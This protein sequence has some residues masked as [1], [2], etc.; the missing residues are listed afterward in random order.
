MTEYITKLNQLDLEIDNDIVHNQVNEIKQIDNYIKSKKPLPEAPARLGLLPDQF[1]D[2]LMEI[3]ENKRRSLTTINNLFN[4][5][6]QYLSLEY[7]IWSVAN[8]KTARLIKEKLAI[9][10]A[11]EI[12][13]G[14]AYWSKALE[15]A[16]IITISTDSLE[17]AKT[18]KTGS[19]P[20]Y[21]VLDMPAAQAIEKYRDVD[22]ILCSWSPN[23]GQGD[24]ETVNAW[25]KYNKSSHLLF[26]GE[27]NGATNSQEFW[28]HSWLKK[29][30]ELAEINHSFKSFDFINEQIF[31]ID[32]EF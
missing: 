17:W 16:G 8:L 27:Q 6:R 10:K 3:G 12:M 18:S 4:N 29:T 1:E 7:G 19:E 26:I 9:N 23:F 22:L 24:I 2:V 25:Q 30:P 20:F 14:N 5:C 31:E 21:Q 11:L 13:A 32:N 15:A 28:D